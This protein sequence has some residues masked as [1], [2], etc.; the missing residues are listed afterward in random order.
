[1]Q[2]PANAS[3]PEKKLWEQLD[4]KRMPRHV[5]IIMDGNGRWARD[6]GLPRVKGHK[7][8]VRALRQAVD[9]VLHL[10]LDSITIYAFSTENWGRPRFEV[11]VLMTLLRQFV[12]IERDRLMEK[13]V[14]LRVLGDLDRLPG[15]VRTAVDD[16]LRMTADNSRL[17]FN[18][19]LNYGGRDEILT[20]VRKLI[21]DGVSPDQVTADR[22]ESGLYTA[23]LPD[24]DLLIRTS[25]E[26]RISN[27]LLWQLA[28]TELYFTDVYWPDFDTTRMLNALLDYQHRIRRFGGVD[29]H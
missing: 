27:F 12:R 6:R 18:I 8:G 2:P 13:N 3:A 16:I 22:F 21:Q 14:R 19:A 7:A 1:M 10:G 29:G 4:P 28:Y 25:G 5:A 9:T 17:N 15:P 11:S 24:P 23:G 26:L 20:A